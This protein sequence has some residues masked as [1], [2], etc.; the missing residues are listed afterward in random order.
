MQEAQETDEA[1]STEAP[2]GLEEAASSS[3]ADDV[4]SLHGRSLPVRL[5]QYT[6]TSLTNCSFFLLRFADRAVEKVR[7]LRAASR[8]AAR[9]QG[10]ASSTSRP[11]FAASHASAAVQR[12]GLLLVVLRLVRHRPAAVRDP[13]FAATFEA[14]SV[15]FFG[16][17]RV[18]GHCGPRPCRASVRQ[19]RSAYMSDDRPCGCEHIDGYDGARQQ[20][21]RPRGN[22]ILH[23]ICRRSLCHV[24]LF[25]RSTIW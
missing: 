14:P 12:V 13:I 19:V 17:R 8:P 25:C 1:V 5:V 16:G 23:G 24:R 10:H 2:Q 4:S 15:R 6:N 18:R 9:R 3:S 20:L 11:P 7:R 22:K 21:P